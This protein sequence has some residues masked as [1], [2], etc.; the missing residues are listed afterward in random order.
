M[1]KEKII[2]EILKR[3]KLDSNAIRKMEEYEYELIYKSFSKVSPELINDAIESY[4]RM[5]FKVR[6]VKT[7]FH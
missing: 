4:K 2:E 7:T 6:V 3:F 5:D 1:S